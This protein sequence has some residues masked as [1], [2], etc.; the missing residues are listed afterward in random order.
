[1]TVSSQEAPI[2]QG[3]KCKPSEPVEYPSRRTDGVTSEND[4]DTSSQT[5]HR[6]ARIPSWGLAPGLDN[7]HEFHQ[8]FINFASDLRQQMIHPAKMMRQCRARRIGSPAQRCNAPTVKIKVMP[9]PL[10]RILPLTR[11]TVLIPSAYLIRMRNFR[12]K[13]HQE[14]SHVGPVVSIQAGHSC[15]TRPHWKIDAPSRWMRN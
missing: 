15:L 4:G 8:A 12:E 10:F 3:S 2:R 7:S 14:L 5:S 1:M 6:R 11:C 9:Y 13:D